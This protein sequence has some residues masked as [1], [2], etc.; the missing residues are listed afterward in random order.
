MAIKLKIH[1]PEEETSTEPD[2]L[3][4]RDE[5]SQLSLEE[6]LDA[7]EWE[8]AGKR[9]WNT[10]FDPGVSD[11]DRTQLE[12]DATVCYALVKVEGGALDSPE[13]DGLVVNT[14][15]D[16]KPPRTE[17]VELYKELINPAKSAKLIMEKDALIGRK[18]NRRAVA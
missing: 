15:K 13:W 14:L 5:L 11:S 16:Q 18:K 6:L 1:K 10:R 7:S 4:K 17:L 12:H 3:Q 8:A 2:F 9:I